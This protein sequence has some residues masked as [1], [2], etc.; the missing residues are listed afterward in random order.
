MNEKI[1]EISRPV[2]I[3]KVHTKSLISITQNSVLR[4]QNR[5]LKTAFMLQLLII[6]RLIRKDLV[7]GKESPRRYN[8]MNNVVLF[9]SATG[10]F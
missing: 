2:K 5:N 7:I 1:K 3:S 10:E 6:V 9:E 4:F 8:I